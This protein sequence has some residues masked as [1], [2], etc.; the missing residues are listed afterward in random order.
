M[1]DSDDDLFLH[2]RSEPLEA[3]APVAAHADGVGLA[4]VDLTICFGQP[5][6]I[7]A[8]QRCCLL[9]GLGSYYQIGS[10][11]QVICLW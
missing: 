9:L 4:H 7:L 1:S 10:V 6:N 2:V 5:A 3:Q 11:A 8:F